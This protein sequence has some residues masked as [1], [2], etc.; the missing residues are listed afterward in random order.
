ME[1]IQLSFRPDQLKQ[2]RDTSQELGLSIAG[3]VRLAVYFYF[4]DKG[5]T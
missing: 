1:K 4:Q 5:E 3:V 2:L